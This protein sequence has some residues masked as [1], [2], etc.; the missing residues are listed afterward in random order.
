M[1]GPREIRV[2]IVDAAIH[3]LAKGPDISRRQRSFLAGY[4]ASLIQP[5]AIDH[6]KIL[7][8]VR[9]ELPECFLWYGVLSGLTPR[10][11]VLNYDNGLGWLINRELG[12]TT[13]WLDP[14][15]CD[16][17]LTEMEI[18]LRD[19]ENSRLE[20]RTFVSGLLR[21]ELFP[22]IYTGVK[23][24]ESIEKHVDDR[25]LYGKQLTLFPEETRLTQ[26]VQ[27]L[28][29]KIQETSTSLN[30]IRRQVETRF[31]QKNPRRQKKSKN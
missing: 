2:K 25:N 8:P 21:I 18:L 17:A 5:G 12:R 16:I 20:M 27:E 6:F 30:A 23:W 3:E 22:L 7:F 31:G 4:L 11:S 9:S 1:T 14:P 10:S 15:D 19:R 28:L 26:D 24:S 13:N 29:S